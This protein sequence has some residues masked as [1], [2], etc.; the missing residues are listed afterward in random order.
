MTTARIEDLIEDF[1]F[2]P[3]TMVAGA[4]V[5][6]IA[7]A[8]LSG[9]VLPPIEVDEKTK[10]VIDGFHRMAAHRKAGLAETPVDWVQCANEQEF[11]ARAVGANA[12]HGKPYTP[13]ERTQIQARAEELGFSVDRIGHVLRMPVESLVAQR[14]KGFAFTEDGKALVIKHSFAWKAGQEFTPRQIDANKRSN[15]MSISFNAH[16]V[17]DALEADLIDWTSAGTRRA[18]SR[19][20]TLLADTSGRFEVSELPEPKAERTQPAEIIL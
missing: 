9:Q 15:G 19:L 5:K 20:Y 17:S 13:Y 14:K 16:Q 1:S 2:Y 7:D 6:G 12:G 4:H 10:R 18:L 11:Y 8:I 3:R